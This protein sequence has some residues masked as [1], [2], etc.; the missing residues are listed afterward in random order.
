M[1]NLRLE[2]VASDVPIDPEKLADALHIL[3][4]WY[5]RKQQSANETNLDNLGKSP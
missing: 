1:E 2:A 3:A 4:L 5:V